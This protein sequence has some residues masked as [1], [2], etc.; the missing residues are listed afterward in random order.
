MAATLTN[1]PTLIYVEKYGLKFLIFDTPSE[2]NL[3]LYIKE[4]Q[5]HNVKHVV[6]VCQATYP[7]E[8]VE[9]SQIAFHVRVRKV[10]FF[11][12]SGFFCYF[13]QD[14][15]FRL[16]P[17]FSHTNLQFFNF[18]LAVCFAFSAFKM[19]RIGDS[20]TV[21]LPHSTSSRTGSISSMKPFQSTTTT[22]LV[23][24]A[25]AAAPVTHQHP[26]HNKRS[27]AYQPSPFTV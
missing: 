24:L 11:C 26:H 9:R 21:A 5:K 15:F 14:F 18:L 23:V 4:F 3:H 22:T 8:I 13:F 19:F 1:K 7:R 10:H 16:A 12:S 6:R 17:K 20:M 25:A 27:I 2:R